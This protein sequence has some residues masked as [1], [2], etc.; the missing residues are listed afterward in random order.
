N[1][2]FS[3]GKMHSDCAANGCRGR[4]FSAAGIDKWRG[5]ERR[6][7][8][9]SGGAELCRVGEGCLAA[10]E[11]TEGFT[12]DLLGEAGALAALGA[13]AQRLAH[14]TVAAATFIDCILDLAVGDALAEAD[15]HG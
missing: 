11:V 7:G 15:V 6:K 14:V 10:L 3:H 5:L 2:N 9:R 13:Y 8:R 12:N 1:A 4:G